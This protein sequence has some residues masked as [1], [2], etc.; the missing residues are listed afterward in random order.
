MEQN[1]KSIFQDI[2]N[3]LSDK[4]ILILFISATV[5]LSIICIFFCFFSAKRKS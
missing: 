5:F 4:E 2:K 1:K 3:I